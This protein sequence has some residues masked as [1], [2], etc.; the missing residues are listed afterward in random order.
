MDMENLFVM[1]KKLM[2]QIINT[3]KQIDVR[4]FDSM[5]ALVGCVMLLQQGMNPPQAIADTNIKEGTEQDG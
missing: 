5:D 4:G 3:L 2:E 1:D